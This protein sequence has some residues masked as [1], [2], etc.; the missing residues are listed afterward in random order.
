M[1]HATAMTGPEFLH[2]V[3]DAEDAQGNHVNADIY[4]QRANAWA[5]DLRALQLLRN[6]VQN[7]EDR[8]SA[9]ACALRA[10]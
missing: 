8:L 4:R 7:L 10:A 1:H 2:A 5:A 9:A 3:A 6:E